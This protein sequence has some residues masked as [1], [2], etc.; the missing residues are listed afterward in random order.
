MS[1]LGTLSLSLSLSL[2][3]LEE[4]ES[5]SIDERLG[6]SLSLSQYEGGYSKAQKL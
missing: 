2:S 3:L 4:E 5:S 6:D 1:V